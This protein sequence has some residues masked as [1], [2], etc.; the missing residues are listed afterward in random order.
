MKY[1]SLLVFFVFLS[2]KSTFKVLERKDILLDSLSIRAIYPTINGVWFGGTN[3]K[4]GFISFQNEAETKIV[5]LQKEITDFRSIA[6][7]NGSIY[8]LNAGTPA[9]MYALNTFGYSA[10]SNL[11]YSENGEKV[12]YDSMFIDAKTGLGIVVGDPTKDCLSVLLTENSGKSWQKISC[13]LLPKTVEGEAAFAASDTNVKI[14]DGVIYIISGGTKSRLFM[15]Q[16]KGST[17]QVFDTPIIQGKAMTGAFSMDFYNKSKG[18]IVGGNYENQKDNSI[19]K[20]IT[21]DGGKTWDIVSKDKAFGYASCVQFMPKSRGKVLFTCGTSGVYCST[22]FG[23]K[24]T[25]ILDDTD[26][27]TLRFSGENNIYLAGKNKVT[28]IKISH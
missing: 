16:D 28:K 11:I 14:V 5:K 4:A 1:L 27:Y 26:F 8:V 24:W 17:W 7:A 2:C 22:N 12:F 10:T 13:D 3:S 6:Y 18:I 21:K 25:K 9:N 20:A 15:S 19:N 23:E